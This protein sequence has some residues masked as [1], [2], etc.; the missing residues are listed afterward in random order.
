MPYF[1]DQIYY[2]DRYQDQKYIYRHVLLT[3]AAYKKCI[4]LNK[5]LKENEWRALG[6]YM[7]PGW[8]HFMWFKGEKNV[9]IFRRPK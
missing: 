8:V 6:L 2:S 7:S 5:L 1:P 3:L 4:N 9:L